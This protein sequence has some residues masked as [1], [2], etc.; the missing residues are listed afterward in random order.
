MD[1]TTLFEGCRQRRPVAAS[2]GGPIWSGHQAC[3][4]WSFVSAETSEA[5]AGHLRHDLSDGTWDRMHGF[6]R[7]QPTFDGSL[8]LVASR[9]LAT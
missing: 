3:S 9:P 2:G 8:R 4:A 5:H 6:L 1:G 7:V